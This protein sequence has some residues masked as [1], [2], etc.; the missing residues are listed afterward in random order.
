MYVNIV[1]QHVLFQSYEYKDEV[2]YDLTKFL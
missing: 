2:C 1:S